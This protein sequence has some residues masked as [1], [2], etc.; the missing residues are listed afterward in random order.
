MF[1]YSGNDLY[2]EQVALADV[3]ARVGTPAYVYSSQTILTNYRAYDEAFGALP[4]T[5]CYAVKAN[6]SLAVLALLAKAGAGFDIVSGGELA[7]VLAAGGDPSRVVFSGVG[8]TAAEVE[9]ALGHGIHSF[10]CES[11]P[12]LALLDAMAARRGVKA[13]FSIRV[14]PDVDAVTHPYIATG[15]G[16]HKFGIAIERAHAVYERARGYANLSAEGVSCHIGSQILDASPI[17]EAVDMLVEFARQ[18]RAEGC[19][20]RHLDLGGGLGIAYRPGEEAPAVAQFVEGLHAKLRDTGLEVMVEPGR[21]IVGAAGVLLTRVLYRK[22]NGEKEFIVVDAAMNDL[23]RPAL[24]HAHHEIVPLRNN[25]LPPVTA[26]VVGPICESG[27]FLARDRLM[28]NAM[29]GDYLAVCAAGAYGFV[30]SSNYNSRPRAPEVLVE[31]AGYRV[32]RER[33]TYVDL[34]RGETV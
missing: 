22:Q 15:L 12:E 11:E 13:G 26:D 9:Y 16:Q 21:S 33:E 2:C 19:P 24:Y 32:I 1:S 7:R 31:G 4:H 30:Q 29:P 5:V 18:L 6:S 17:L 8:K 20:V 28:A 10:N 34:M 25:G 27:D 3:A 14:N 23:I